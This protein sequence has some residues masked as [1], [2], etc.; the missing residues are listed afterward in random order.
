MSDTVIECVGTRMA[1]HPCD[2]LD[3]ALGDEISELTAPDK[4][5]NCL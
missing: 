2:V 5:K 1:E 4:P 3:I